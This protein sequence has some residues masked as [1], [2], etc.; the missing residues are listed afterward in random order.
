MKHLVEHLWKCNREEILNRS[1]LDCHAKGLHSIMLS[2]TPRN[3]IRLYV[4]MPDSDITTV[5]PMEDF[6]SP[7]ISYHPHHCN[8]TLSCVSGTLFN[9]RIA[10]TWADDVDAF[11]IDRYKYKSKIN[12]GD[13]RFEYGGIAYMEHAA[14]HQVNAGQSLWMHAAD[15]HTVLTWSGQLTA[16][17]VFEGN[18]D[19]EYAPYAYSNRDLA[20]QDFSGLYNK[21]SEED[22]Y[23][24][25]KSV[26]LLD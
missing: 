6:Q 21:P 1:L 5:K 16:W 22:V 18:E 9:N 13:I 17:F 7:P 10:P 15:V 8:L 24:L 12:T 26:N 2:D 19:P 20:N 25:L 4:S 3:R 23:E 11:E 14:Y